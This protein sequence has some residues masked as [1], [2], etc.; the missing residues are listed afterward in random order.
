MLT[1]R[2]SLRKKCPP[3]LQGGWAEKVLYAI[4]VMIDA[5]V[6]SANAAVRIRFPGLYSDESLPLIGRERR[7]R[8]GRNEPASTYSVRLMRWLDD[9]A[10]RGG[11]YAL[12]EQLHAYYAD[13]PFPIRLVYRSGRCFDMDVDGEITMSDVVWSPDEEPECWARWWLIY[14]WPTSF[15]AARKY[16]DGT[17]Y[18]QG[19]VY[20][21]GLL[22]GEVADLR[23]IPRDW[24]TAHA[25]GRLIVI[26]PGGIV[27]GY[28]PRT[29]GDGA[30][31]GGGATA[32]IGV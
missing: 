23:V 14:Q 22:S 24:N 4:G 20:G 2:D 25:L 16:G 31:Y 30:T 8:R 17:Q 18:G 9:H 1:F 27:Y 32:N 29:Y 21:S 19:R 7:I 26:S 6:D 5:L 28:P 10:T 11:P 3:W 13:D 15:P 12:L